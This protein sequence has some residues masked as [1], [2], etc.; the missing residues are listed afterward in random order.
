MCWKHASSLLFI[1]FGNPKSTKKWIL[2]HARPDGSRPTGQVSLVQKVILEFSAGPSGR[3]NLSVQTEAVQ[4]LL[5]SVRMLKLQHF[6]LSFPTTPILSQSDI[7]VK[8]YDQ[9]TGR[10]PD[11]LTER[12]DDQLQPPLQ[13]SAESFHNKA[14]SGRCCPS[15]RTVALRIHE[16]TIIRLGASGPWRLTSELLNRCTQFP[17]IKLDRSDGWTWYARSC[18]IEDIVRTGSHIV[19]TVAAVFP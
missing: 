8:R 19:R 1:G 7:W 15:V 10:C 4:T 18:L 13:D 2:K 3:T 12:P 9:N 11:G 14:A 17:Y 5:G 16:I 6:F